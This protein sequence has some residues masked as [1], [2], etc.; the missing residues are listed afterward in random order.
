[1]KKLLSVFLCALLVFS[2]G[3]PAFAAESSDELKITVVNDIHYNGTYT[4]KA[5]VSKH[6]TLSADFAHVSSSGKLV[7]ESLALF[8]AFLDEASKNDSK[9]VLIP[10]DIV[11][12]GTV[13]EHETVVGMLTAF[14]ETCGKDVY[15][16]PGNHDLFKTT[17]AEFVALYDDFGYG[18]ALAVDTLSA[19]YTIDLNDEYR[20][21]AID[22]TD[23]GNGP[24]GMTQARLDWIDAQCDQAKADGKKVIAMMHHN[25]LDHFTPSYALHLGEA[26]NSDI[27]IADVFAEGMVKYTFTGH[28]HAQDILSY[29]AP[30][31]TVIYDVV[32][33]ALAA[34]PC[35]Y[36]EVTFGDTVIIETKNITSVDT[37]LIPDG[38][39]E[40]ALNILN[41]SV[42]DYSHEAALI[43]NRLLI[44]S[45]ITP[46]KIVGLIGIDK[47]TDPELYE[48]IYN[49]GKKIAEATVMPLYEKDADGGNSIEAY[50]KQ[51]N[52]TL[53]ASDYTDLIDVVVSV[54]TDY[55]AGVEDYPAYSDETVI[56]SRGLAATLTYA[57]EDLT[58][59]EYSAVLELLFDFIKVDVPSELIDFSGNLITNFENMEVIVATAIVPIL[60]NMI[61]DA[62]PEDNNV[63]LAGYETAGELELSFWDKIKAFFQSIIDFVKSFF[64]L[65]MK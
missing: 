17:V 24:H 52:K 57:L 29:T 39:S 61:D 64:S 49:V 48:T 62:A 37:S 63:T 55:Q 41:T 16:I 42:V 51:F 13:E 23:P 8:S 7:Y 2:L 46:Q 40:A 65:F 4:A 14:E 33:G 15:V 22:S 30:N 28:I 54:Y 43:S 1:M 35:P 9:V 56:M 44:S 12:V 38:I 26:V 21:L 27:N 45:S 11:D 19:S 3:V 31:G 18:D 6:N 20:L 34:Y 60:T 53:P 32:T 47:E 10:G 36:R 58:A 5:T 25:L 50:V 59:E